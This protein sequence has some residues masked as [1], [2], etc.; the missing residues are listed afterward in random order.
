MSFLPQGMDCPLLDANALRDHF[1]HHTLE[2]STFISEEI[3]SLR[4]VAAVMK[5]NLFIRDV[6][7]NVEVDG[8]KLKEYLSV[9]E[10]LV[11]LYQAPLSR[12]N[13]FSSS[14]TV[15]EPVR[16]STT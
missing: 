7:G 3:R 11:K 1:L 2:P 5:R 15:F 4:D 14:T 6:T 16:R 12:M 9:Q 8:R 13:F 10:Q